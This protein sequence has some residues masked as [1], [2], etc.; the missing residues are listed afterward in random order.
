[1]FL[2]SWPKKVSKCHEVS[3]A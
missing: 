2:F 1:M 3:C